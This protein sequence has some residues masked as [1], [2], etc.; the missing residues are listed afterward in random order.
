MIKLLKRFDEINLLN[1]WWFINGAHSEIATIYRNF[2][3][4]RESLLLRVSINSC[5]V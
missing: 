3:E 2:E 1:T 4:E 5:Y